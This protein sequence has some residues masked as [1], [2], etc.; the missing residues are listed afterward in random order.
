MKRI[1]ASE[2]GYSQANR[3]YLLMWVAVVAVWV[4]AVYEYRAVV[5]RR[6]AANA[7]FEK[8][9]DLSIAARDAHTGLTLAVISGATPGDVKA[10]LARLRSEVL[11]ARNLMERLAVAV[12]QH[13]DLDEDQKAAAREAVTFRQRL[14]VYNQSD[15]GFADFGLVPQGAPKLPRAELPPETLLLASG[16][17]SLR[18]DDAARYL[19]LSTIRMSEI[20]ENEAAL[21]RAAS[22]GDLVAEL[23]RFPV[24]ETRLRENAE[25]L[26]T[27]WLT[28]APSEKD[29][30]R[31]AG[32]ANDTTDKAATDLRNL[33]QDAL[34]LG[35]PSELIHKALEEKVAL[36]ARARGEGKEVTLPVL[37]VPLR[38][39][40]AIVGLPYLLALLIAAVSI[41]L[42]RGLRYAPPAVVEADNDADDR[43]VG[44]LPVFFALHGAGIPGGAPVALFLL[45]LPVVLTA[46]GFWLFAGALAELDW[47]AG[48]FWSGV[49][50]D[51]L[52]VIPAGMSIWRT[53]RLMDGGVAVRAV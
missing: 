30:K 47:A 44:S 48:L 21:V 7:V 50:L 3:Y 29:K 42:A 43:L 2:D 37:A 17:G 15:L 18:I 1:E 41:Y 14:L 51:A 22:S 49:A 6:D 12:R 26:Y 39:S 8:Y 5:V 24:L 34:T 16:L 23:D 31:G 33:Q 46:V 20:L 4:T 25:K 27:T 53:V 45:A 32:E 36:A 28:L 19:W 35:A 40:D 11:P 10:T 52:L 9:S 38:L 13:T